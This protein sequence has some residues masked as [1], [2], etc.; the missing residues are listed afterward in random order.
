MH[1]GFVCCKM[2]VVRQ[3]SKVSLEVLAHML[4]YIFPD[5]TT[6]M[7]AWKGWGGGVCGGWGSCFLQHLVNVMDGG[8]RSP[9]DGLC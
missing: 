7:S 4:Q 8:E 6:V 2:Q 9:S 5:G 3:S 1:K